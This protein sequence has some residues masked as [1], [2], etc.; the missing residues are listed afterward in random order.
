MCRKVLDLLTSY[1]TGNL[2][3]ESLEDMAIPLAWEANGQAQDLVDR[4]AAEIALVKDGAS[5]EATFRERMG[6]IV[7]SY[8][9][10]ARQS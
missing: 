3:F 4:I 10:P 9:T 7:A 1:L 6:E 2:G 8:I 5:D